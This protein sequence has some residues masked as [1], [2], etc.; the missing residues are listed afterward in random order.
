MKQ[1]LHQIMKNPGYPVI[2]QIGFA[3]LAL[4]A[5]V[6]TFTSAV[7]PLRADEEGKPRPEAEAKKDNP[8]REG[9][10]NKPKAEEGAAKRKEGEGDKLA[11]AKAEN[12]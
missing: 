2:P 9:D 8:E 6:V 1:R 12:R 4:A 7:T 5:V 11:P 10:A 3:L